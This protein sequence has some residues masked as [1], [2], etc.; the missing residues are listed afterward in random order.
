MAARYTDSGFDNTVSD[1]G[2]HVTCPSLPGFGR[3]HTAHRQRGAS[4]C[5]VLVT[6]CQT[7]KGKKKMLQLFW[8]NLIAYSV[9]QAVILLR[10][11]RSTMLVAAFPLALM[12]PLAGLSASPHVQDPWPWLLA[13]LI[14]SP[15]ALLYVTMA[16]FFVLREQ[17]VA[18]QEYKA[19]APALREP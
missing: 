4:N 14:A 5:A 18:S 7:E 10:C 17:S 19:P 11:S 1:P 6:S 3:M 12:L 13:L 8:L 9:V 15:L 2:M 16:A